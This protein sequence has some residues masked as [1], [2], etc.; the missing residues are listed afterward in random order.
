MS[1]RT[2]RLHGPFLSRRELDSAIQRMRRRECDCKLCEEQGRIGLPGDGSERSHRWM[3]CRQ[4][5]TRGSRGAQPGDP[6]WVIAAP[7]GLGSGR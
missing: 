5:M 6:L 2:G 7:S 3:V 4:P 1:R